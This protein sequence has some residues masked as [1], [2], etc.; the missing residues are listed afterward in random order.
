MHV[1][2]EV[3]A[4]EARIRPHIIKTPVE[5]SPYLSQITG[6][7]VWLKMEHLQI[8][9]SFKLRGATNKVISLSPQEKAKGVITA[10][11]GNHGS[12]F[13]YIADKLGVK[14]TIYLPESAAPAKIEY[15]KM[16]N[17]DL[18][19]IPGDPIEAEKTARATAAQNGQV[20]VSPYNDPQIVGGQGTIGLEILEQVPN[21]D[22]VFVPV[23]GGGLIAGIAGFMKE[24]LPKIE[25]IGCQPENSAVMYESIKAGRVVDIP[26]YPTLSDGTAGGMDSDS[27][28]FE[29]CQKYV[30]DYT[31]ISE[32]EIADGLRFLIKKHYMLV[33][34]AAAL[35]IASL[36]KEKERF[37]GKTVVLILCGRKIGLETLK[38]I[39]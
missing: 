36:L 4:A 6:A 29:I 28:T 33:E 3:L 17:V 8:T 16:Y 20:Y 34:G 5:Y 32:N 1:K 15:M 23:G 38:Q 12:A 10:S 27:I 31:M 35:S 13:A 30:D 2:S 26:T 21:V 11:T 25:I 18:K 24:M 14:G 39:L 19:Y 37:S 22:S 9:G 7:N